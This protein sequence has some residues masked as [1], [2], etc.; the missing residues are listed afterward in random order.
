MTNFQMLSGL[1]F[2]VLRSTQEGDFVVRKLSSTS[3][4]D[5]VCE[6]VR[7]RHGFIAALRHFK[8]STG[9]S[10][11]VCKPVV[12]TIILSNAL[13]Y[14]DLESG[15]VVLYPAFEIDLA[16]SFTRV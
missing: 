7:E 4:E 16:Q 11:Y 14:R 15:R 8:R 13:G 3:L 1:G 9:M 6:I 5:Q 2:F 12:E 10:L